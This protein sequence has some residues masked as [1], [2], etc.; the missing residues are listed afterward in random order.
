MRIANSWFCRTHLWAARSCKLSVSLLVA[1]VAMSFAFG[2]AVKGRMLLPIEVLGANGTSVST[3]FTSKL[4]RLLRCDFSGCRFIGC[5]MR[6]K[7]AFK[8]TMAYGCPSTTA[9]SRSLSPAGVLGESVEDSR[10]S[11]CRFLCRR[12]NSVR[13]LIPSVFGSIK[14]M[15]SPAAIA[16]SPGIS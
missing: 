3:T 12:K 5:G 13:A 1:V 9:L 11:S 15:R 8:S 7:Q 4:N 6:M 10:R 16:Y 14:Q 2:E